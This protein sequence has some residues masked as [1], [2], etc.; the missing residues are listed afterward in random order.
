MWKASNLYTRSS[1]KQGRKLTKDANWESAP[2]LKDVSIQAERA[3]DALHDQAE[4]HSP[5]PVKLQN[6]G[7]QS[8]TLSA[9]REEKETSR[10]G[11]R[12]R[13]E[14][15]LQQHRDQDFGG[16]FSHSNSDQK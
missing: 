12:A 16:N 10:E 3:Q 5:S 2:E 11:L 9:S 7:E 15:L 6:L 14:T 13:H 1:R 4:R 8:K